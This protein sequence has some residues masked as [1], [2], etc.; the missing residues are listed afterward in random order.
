[1]KE[2][3]ETMKKGRIVVDSQPFFELM[4]GSIINRLLFSERLEKVRR[5]LGG[6]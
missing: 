5:T 4:V 1:M 6:G 3:E 2:M